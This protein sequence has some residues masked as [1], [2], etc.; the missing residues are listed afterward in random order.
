MIKFDRIGD[1]NPQL[2]RELKSRLSWRNGLMAI[3][4]SL[5]S[6]VMLLLSQFSKLPN[7][8]SDR[9]WDS[10][11][12]CLAVVKDKCTRDA[13]G[14]ILINWPKWWGEVAV[15]N[16]WLLVYGLIVGGVYLLASSFSQE[17]KRGTLN[18]I[19][20][21]P[22]KASTI[23][24]G[25]LLGVP[26]LV[27][28]GAAL[29]LPLQFYATLQGSISLLNVLSWDILM[30]S[31]ALLLY[32]GAILAT[33]WFNAQSILL[34][35]SSA[36]IAYQVASSSLCW[37]H[38]NNYNSGSGTAWY[39]LPIA[40]HLSFYLL[41]AALTT[42]GIY[43]L[44]CALERRYAQAQSTVL[45]K[46]Q[47]YAWTAM[48]HLFFMGFY[49]YRIDT[50]SKHLVKGG[51]G[52]KIALTFHPPFGFALTSSMN[53]FADAVL[54][55][56]GWVWL[57][58]LIPLLLPSRQS[59]I[60]WSRYHSARLLRSG[61]TLFWADRSPAVLA[62]ALNV[63][64]ASLI[65]IPMIYIHTRGAGLGKLLLGAAITVVLMML[66]SSIA[67]WI[68]FWPVNNRPL[69]IAG[70]IGGLV[71]LPVIGASMISFGISSSRNPLFLLSPF[72]WTSIQGVSGFVGLLI[73]G[74]LCAVTIWVNMQLQK[75]LQKVGRSESFQHLAT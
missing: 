71:M 16:S 36:F 56:F 18:F 24:V 23:F 4:I 66:Y 2:L 20:L 27:Y 75:S 46:A 9:P 31:V 68:L 74:L 14:N 52:T 37:H 19:R 39:G 42:V 73:L 69:W 59:L 45:S 54:G 41:F 22:Q 13:L 12:Y 25:K 61:S 21:T 64:I 49:F 11:E 35:G 67:H 28:L 62:V 7:S 65:W 33:L 15:N 50:I 26:V 55:V 17:E 6:Q 72:V 8:T 51:T 10:T 3:A 38:R 60:E 53:G 63:I 30:I 58:L 57:M 47:S 1:F 44:Y 32:L 43:W 34:A 29:A 48:L 5:V 70:I 40:N